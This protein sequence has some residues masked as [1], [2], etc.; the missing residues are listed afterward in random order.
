MPYLHEQGGLVTRVTEVSSTVECNMTAYLNP[1][2]KH[3]RGEWYGIHKS[4]NIRY[5]LAA[6]AG[7]L[8]H[9]RVENNLRQQ[10]GLPIE[11]VILS[12]G[13]QAQISALI[14]NKRRY[15]IFLDKIENS[16]TNFLHFW[17]DYKDILR[18]VAVEKKIRN[19]KRLPNGEIDPFNSLAGTIDLLALYKSDNGWRLLRLQRSCL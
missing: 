17:D 8:G 10:I 18:I 5:N 3:A 7:T 15:N 9:N 16:Y 14:K 12:K 2:N 19:I 1:I 4:P 11:K 6:I 13:D